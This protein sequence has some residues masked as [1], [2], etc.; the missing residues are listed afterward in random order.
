MDLELTPLPYLWK[1]ENTICE[2][3]PKTH[4]IVQF[5][6]ATLDYLSEDNLLLAEACQPPKQVVEYFGEGAECN[7]AYHFPVMPRIYKGHGR[8]G[9]VGY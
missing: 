4:L 3:L 1:E 2:N 5:F 8:R 7:A 6:K 9:W